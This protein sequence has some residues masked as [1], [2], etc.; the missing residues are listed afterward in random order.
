MVLVLGAG[1][2]VDYGYPTGGTLKELIID[3]NSKRRQSIVNQITEQKI[4][5][6][7]YNVFVESF[8]L[9]GQT[10]I[11][12]FLEKRSEFNDIG[13][14]LIVIYLSSKENV[15]DLFDKNR[16]KQD[17]YSY[18]FNIMDGNSS[19][20]GFGDNKLSI[21]TFNYDRSLETYLFTALRYTYKKTDHEVA[22]V[23]AKI[24]ILHVHGKLGD[25]DWQSDNG[26]TYGEIAGSSKIKQAA[27]SIRII[28]ETTT[29][30]HIFIDA[31]KL[32]IDP[33]SRV[34]FLGFGYHED[35]VTRLLLDTSENPQNYRGTCVG[36]QNAQR[37]KV[38]VIF[39]EYGKTIGFVPGLKVLDYLKTDVVF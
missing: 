5:M 26:I 24:P 32:L 1:A 3:D 38:Q 21:I 13:K 29:K 18:L 17:W 31:R 20:D 35:N 28:S 33:D 14:L 30:D 36:L 7:D 23:L 34:Y 4:S 39:K 37:L 2:S 15:S 22:D 19:F 16:V 25:L 9:S 8:K 12:T 6:R 10:S 27:N 11:D